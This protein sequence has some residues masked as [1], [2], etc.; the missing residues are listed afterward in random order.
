MKFAILLFV[1]LSLFAVKA[2]DDESIDGDMYEEDQ[3]YSQ[4]PQQ[5]Q[6]QV[7]LTPE[8]LSALLVCPYTLQYFH[9]Y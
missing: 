8:M 4:P 6:Q 5:Q 2:Y 7:R 9:S 3:Q 1:L